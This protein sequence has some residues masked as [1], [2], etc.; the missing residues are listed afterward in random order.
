MACF[1]LRSPRDSQRAPQ[2]K[3]ISNHPE[4]ITKKTLRARSK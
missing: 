2:G 1:F 4:E 3:W